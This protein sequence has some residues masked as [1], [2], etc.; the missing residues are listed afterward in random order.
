MVENDLRTLFALEAD[1]D[2]P[3]SPISI[4]AAC[5]SAGIRRRRTRVLAFASPA[6]AGLAVA[7]VALASTAT[8]SLMHR[9]APA[10]GRHPAR[11]GSAAPQYFS[12]L[13]P[14]AWLPA[15]QSTK[16]TGTFTRTS[17][18]LANDPLGEFARVYSASACSVKQGGSGCG[19]QVPAGQGRYVG[20]VH[21]HPA[22]WRLSGP[23]VKPSGA[24][25]WQYA[26]RGWAQ[27]FASDG[28]DALRIARELVFG[29]A[30]GPPVRF[31]FQLTHVPSSWRVNS[32][33]TQW[34]GA[35][36]YAIADVLTASPQ[37]AA[38]TSTGPAFQGAPAMASQSECN[39]L[40][41]GQHRTET[42]NGDQAYV[43][44]NPTSWPESA[45]CSAN[46]DG[47]LVYIAV[48]RDQA[49]SAV[50]L[51]AHHLRLLGPDPAS[52]TTRPI[53]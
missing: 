37:R 4:P 10:A 50:D 9:A 32:V 48:G 47:E 20:Q 19:G 3:P 40:T 28:Q 45:L 17:E 30:A 41:T 26:R 5:R 16:T 8:P 46:A 18:I 36:Q 12:P 38:S 24:L 29:P 35:V 14:Y 42:I 43:S 22:Y 33:S 44:A 49:F 25:V 34:A 6:L 1:A 7:A 31:P 13:R 53:G 21:G 27:V 11:G 23:G 51:F 39:G 15:G 2:Q 52:W